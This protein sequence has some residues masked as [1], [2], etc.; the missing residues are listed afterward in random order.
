MHNI[1]K[2]I[3][4]TI[5]SLLVAGQVFAATTMSIKIEQP[6]SPTNQ[7]SL[8]V[9]FVVL[10]YASNGAIT[11]KCFYSKDAGPVSQFGSDITIS[12]GGGTANCTTDNSIMNGDG[13]Y[14]FY[15]TAKNDDPEITSNTVD[16][17]L[18][19]SG[20]DTPTSYSKEDFES[21]KYKIKFHTADDG[22]TVKVELY[23]S[24]NTTFDV[25]AGS[26]VATQNIGPN[27]DG[28][29]TTDKPDCS[30]T[31]Y[32]VIRAFDSSGNGSGIRGDSETH[33]VTTTILPTT[34][35]V[36]G[37]IPAGTNGNV[38]GASN[39]P[40][41][42]STG[43]TGAV[44]GEE[45]TPTITPTPTPTPKPTVFPGRNIGIGGGILVILIIIFFLFK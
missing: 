4:I 5:I 2:T 14:H 11:A 16:V 21:C 1:F 28:Q 9:N 22:K 13:T 15:V 38:L 31:Y 12:K 43:A 32:Y 25:N 6:K 39:G 29:F 24:P 42:G 41:G 45:V 27:T 19:T 35:T 7:T 37:A 23:R 20:P 18:N 36:A 44:L 33:T 8:N 3:G 26:L 40:L 10:D 34:T 30:K 17:T